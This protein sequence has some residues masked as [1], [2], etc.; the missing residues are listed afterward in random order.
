MSVCLCVGARRV[1][2]SGLNRFVVYVFCVEFNRTAQFNSMQ[3][4]TQSESIL[5]SWGGGLGLYKVRIVIVEGK[6][7]NGI[8]LKSGNTTGR[9]IY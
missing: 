7:G 3:L 5:G 9:I 8:I 4:K 6:A 1:Y 2:H